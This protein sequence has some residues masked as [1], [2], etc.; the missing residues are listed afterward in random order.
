[1]YAYLVKEYKSANLCHEKKHL[2]NL[3]NAGI[4]QSHS[5]RQVR[6]TVHPFVDLQ[7][8]SVNVVFRRIP[9]IR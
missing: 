8:K 9:Q 2:T 5:K 6:R 1:M 7:S 4:I 3:G